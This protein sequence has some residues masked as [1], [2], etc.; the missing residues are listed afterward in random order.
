MFLR[1]AKP[2]ELDDDLLTIEFP[3]TFHRGKIEERKYRD[4]VE[5]ALEKFIGN[6]LRIKGVVSQKPPEPKP[7][8]RDDDKNEP[9]E[10]VDPVS[11][12]GTLD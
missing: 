6:H 3:Y 12:F 2:I 11:I 1:S 7:L 10:E 4:V 5:A 8:T 9:K